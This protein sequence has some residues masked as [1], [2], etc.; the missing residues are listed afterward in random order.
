[1]KWIF[2]IFILT[3]LFCF[4]QNDTSQ[5][6]YKELYQLVW[7]DFKGKPDFN[8]INAANSSTG[9]DISTN[10]INDSL[11]IRVIAF[12][13]PHKS[14]VKEDSKKESLLKHEQFHFNISELLAR[15]LRKKLIGYGFTHTT[16]KT[17]IGIIFEEAL[18]D[19]WDKQQLYDN[20]TNH[21]LISEKQLEWEDLVYRQL[22][23]LKAYS[24][25]TIKLILK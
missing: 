10:L 18:N 5:I 12:F 3:P 8:S 13:T 14:W 4:A 25:P 23:A 16:I 22:R 1:M 15:K 2:T 7:E 9:I 17:D 24:N 11:T 6:E 21:H 20:E 19:L